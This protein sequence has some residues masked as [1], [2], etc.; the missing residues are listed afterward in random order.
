MPSNDHTPISEAVFHMLLSLVDGPMHGYG[1]IQD[2][3]RR[4]GGSVVLGSGTL[5]SA[6]KRM[7]RDGW[8]AEAT[9]ADPED[10]RRRYYELT[11]LGR[12]VVRAEARRLDAMVRHAHAKH[13]LA[14]GPAAQ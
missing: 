5:Y 4:T 11:E 9:V 14:D 8:L 1:M 6:I 12:R 3:E 2:V 13:L 10:P 7:R